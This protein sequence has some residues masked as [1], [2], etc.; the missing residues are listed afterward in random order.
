VKACSPWSIS[1]GEKKVMENERRKR[2]RKSLL[3]LLSNVVG[4]TFAKRLLLLR[5][6]QGVKYL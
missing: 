6:Q 2:K 5:G 3:S 4:V 1:G